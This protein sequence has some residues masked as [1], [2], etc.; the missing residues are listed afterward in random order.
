MTNM[1]ETELRAQEGGQERQ[2][3]QVEV[4]AERPAD[5]DFETER[6]AFSEAATNE[7]SS[8]A[9]SSEAITN[10]LAEAGVTNLDE[11]SSFDAE[12]EAALLEFQRQMNELAH[13]PTLRPAD[14]ITDFENSDTIFPGSADQER[15]GG[16]ETELPP[17]LRSAEFDPGDTI[18]ANARAES[19]AVSR[20]Y[21]GSAGMDIPKSSGDAEKLAREMGIDVGEDPESEVETQ[22]RRIELDLGPKSPDARS[23]EDFAKEINSKR[24]QRDAL[25][26]LLRGPLKDNQEVWAEFRDLEA[27][28]SDLEDDMAKSGD[29]FADETLPTVPAEAPIG[30]SP[31]MYAEAPPL[32]TEPKKTNV[33]VKG[34]DADNNKE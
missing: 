14:T 5:G 4:S 18:P 21:L 10:R 2:E 26:E 32:R 6:A 27:E 23:N 1:P 24:N 12:A 15:F 8:F 31:T 22:P 20:N 9:V 13:S 11:L 17:T 3:S 33:E 34:P 25:H 7:L 28:I 16:A 30:S 29:T 19:E